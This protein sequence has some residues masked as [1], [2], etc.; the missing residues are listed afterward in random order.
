[1]NWRRPFI[2]TERRALSLAETLVAG[3]L[4]VGLTG[5]LVLLL[6]QNS[7]ARA[8][9]ETHTDAS[10]MALISVE[11]IRMEMRRAKVIKTSPSGDRLTYWVAQVVNGNWA[12][13]PIGQPEWVPGFPA[14][15][16]LAE[17]YISRQ[18]LWRDFQGQHQRLSQVGKDGLIK[19]QYDSAQH[20]LRVV[21]TVGEALATDMARSNRLNLNFLIH[22]ANQ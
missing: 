7:L 1:M 12:L 6:R 3:A 4:L 13:T 8:K 20:S 5:L 17:M 18:T 11:K 9:I 2:T 19:F 10:Q 15:P 16:D 14:A 22:L 21:L